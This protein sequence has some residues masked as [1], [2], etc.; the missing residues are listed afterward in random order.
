MKAVLI[1]VYIILLF[2]V[3][4]LP[5][6]SQP[7]SLFAVADSNTV[8]LWDM[9]AHRNCAAEYRMEITN[10]G[11]HI[12][13][14]QRDTNSYAYCYCD[15]DYYVKFGPLQP[16]DYIADVFFTES[17]DTILIPL[18][19]ISFSILNP[20]TDSALIFEPF[21][22]KCG[23][24]F[25]NTQ[26]N[27]SPKAS[28]LG[29]N[30]PNPFSEFTRIPVHTGPVEIEIFNSIGEKVLELSS[31]DSFSTEIIMT[32]YDETGHR[33]SPGIYYYSVRSGMPE[34]YYRMAIID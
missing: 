5:A 23:G 9:H 30:Y 14:V 26:E 19:N 17:G 4:T 7:D 28:I 16:G 10:E 24:L 22:S 1:S 32:P 12:T 6:I 13:W 20:P 21:S 29:Q 33:F 27:L 18:G 8:T 31:T 25:L 3:I 15:F 11:Q 34:T 2:F